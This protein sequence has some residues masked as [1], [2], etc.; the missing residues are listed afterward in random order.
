MSRRFRRWFRGSGLPAVPGGDLLLRDS[1]SYFLL[2]NGV[3]KLL[4]GH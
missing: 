3:D 1:V 2:R 4:L